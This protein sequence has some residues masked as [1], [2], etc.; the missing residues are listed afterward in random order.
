LRMGRHSDLLSSKRPV[1][2][3]RA[4]RRFAKWI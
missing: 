2:A 4:E 1:S 3:Q